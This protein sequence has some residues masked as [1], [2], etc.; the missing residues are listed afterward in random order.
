MPILFLVTMA[1]TFPIRKASRGTFNWEKA[2]N[3]NTHPGP[4]L[5]FGMVSITPFSGA[6]P[7][8]YGANEKTFKGAPSVNNNLVNK[9]RG[10]THFQ[11]SGTGDIGVFYNLL[12]VYPFTED[13]G[14]ASR[15]SLFLMN[16]P[17]ASPGFFGCTIDEN[18]VDV[19][20][21]TSNKVAYHRYTFPGSATA[22][23]IGVELTA[24]GPWRH[25]KQGAASRCGPG[26]RKPNRGRTRGCGLHLL[27]RHGSRW[28]RQRKRLLRAGRHRLRGRQN[29][30]TRHLSG[31]RQRHSR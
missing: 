28:H 9:A 10:F 8:G 13:Y 30:Y 24:A 5:P 26:K 4:Q 27:L 16:S 14:N 7:T 31:D 29:D 17:T 11:Q 21:T 18:D 6:Y 23:R 25:T 2:Q 19:E 12:R 3:G 15:N 22:R 20:L 1:P